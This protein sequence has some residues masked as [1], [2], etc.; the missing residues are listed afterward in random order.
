[1]SSSSRVQTAR[2]D[3][4]GVSGRPE[5]SDHTVR[6]A[7]EDPQASPDRGVRRD[8]R[9]YRGKEGRLGHLGSRV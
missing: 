6:P 5:T 9:G 1:M 3:L 8:Y 7:F 4:R 2:G